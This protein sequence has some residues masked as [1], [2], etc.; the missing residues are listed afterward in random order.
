M[1]NQSLSGFE[2]SDFAKHQAHLNIHYSTMNNRKAE[3]YFQQA[4]KVK[5]SKASVKKK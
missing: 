1:K 5:S 2:Y 3:G 4:E